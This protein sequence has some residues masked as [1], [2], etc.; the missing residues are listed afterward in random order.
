L[1]V[2]YY[3]SAFIIYDI[4]IPLPNCLLIFLGKPLITSRLRKEFNKN[5]SNEIYSNSNN[6]MQRCNEEIQNFNSEENIQNSN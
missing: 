3:L 1:L 6:K 5:N 2:I 4:P